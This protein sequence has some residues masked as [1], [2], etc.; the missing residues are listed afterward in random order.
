MKN[1][2]YKRRMNQKRKRYAKRISGLTVATTLVLSTPIAPNVLSSSAFQNIVGTTVA[3]A[4]VDN[5]MDFEDTYSHNT[6]TKNDYYE[7]MSYVNFETVYSIKDLGNESEL[8]YFLQFPEELA[9]MLQDDYALERLFNENSGGFMVTGTVKYSDGT[10]DSISRTKLDHLPPKYV[11][12]DESTNS[13]KFDITQ[14]LLDNEIEIPTLDEHGYQHLG[15][16]APFQ[17]QFGNLPANGTYEVK[18]ALV[19]IAASSV[20][21]NDVTNLRTAEFIVEDT[22]EGNQRPEPQDPEPEDPEEPEDP[23][24]PEPEDPEEPED[25]QDPEPEDPE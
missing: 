25:P 16:D 24:D 14:F 10:I 13:I 3:H 12:I 21:F 4:A 2:D 15:I 17:L 7:H 6:E 1:Y 19:P 18:T 5:I 9:Y 23:Q 22:D 20:S 11:T 8:T